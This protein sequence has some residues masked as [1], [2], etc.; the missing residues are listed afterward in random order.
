MT[1]Q[2]YI[3]ICKFLREKIKGTQWEG[4]VFTVGGCCRDLVLG[5]EIHDVDLAVDLPNGGVGFADWLHAQRL[6]IGRP[7]IFARYGTAMLRLRD[8]PK[9]DIEIV[10]TR[11]EK[12]TDKNSRNPLTA[13]GSIKDDCMRRDLTI[14]ALYYDI[15]NQKLLDITGRSL[16]DIRHKVIATPMDPDATYD[17][18]PIRILRTARFAGRLGWTI[19]PEVFEAMSRNVHRLDIIKP[20]RLR[21]EFEKMLLGENAGAA[22]DIL[23]ACGVMNEIAPELT[24][25]YTLPSTA[26]A[27]QSVWSRSLAAIDL[28]PPDLPLR[29]AALLAGAGQDAPDPAMVPAKRMETVV[30]VLSRLKYHRPLIKDV[31]FLTANHDVAATWGKQAEYMDDSALRRLQFLCTRPDKF[32]V[33]MQL[34]DA[35]NRALPADHAMPL[36]AWEIRNREEQMRAAGTSMYDYHLPFAER[37]IKKLLHVEAGPLVEDTLDYMMR[38][39]FDNPSRSKSEFERMVSKYEPHEPEE[40]ALLADELRPCCKQNRAAKRNNNNPQPRTKNRQQQPKNAQANNAPAPK[41]EKG[42]NSNRRRRYS[43]HRP[44]KKEG[45]AS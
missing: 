26:D 14:N 12:Y 9:D 18:D 24:P 3:R 32:D 41:Q 25:L 27:G 2:L 13:F 20:E 16:A 39:A 33:L 1:T 44:R 10:Q 31:L 43:C 8:F 29:W 6:S 35:Y 22:L 42:A 17:D 34:I 30:M 38:L 40:G 23:R 4:H 21:A 45:G 7:V 36:Q 37:R 19:P 5:K 28:L 11:A 15:T